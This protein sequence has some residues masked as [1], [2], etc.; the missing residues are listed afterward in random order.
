MALR[1]IRQEGDEI[2]KKKSRPVE[3][4]DEKI[5]ELIKSKQQKKQFLS[6][7][8]IFCKKRLFQLNTI[9]FDFHKNQNLA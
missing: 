4:I 2:L 3:E 9:F 1:I 6:R 8:K 7:T 5:K